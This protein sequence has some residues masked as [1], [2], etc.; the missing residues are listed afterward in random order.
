MNLNT[1]IGFHIMEAEEKY[2]AVVRELRKAKANNRVIT[3]TFVKSVFAN[4][5]FSEDLLETYQIAE[6]NKIIS[7]LCIT[8]T[9]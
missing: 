2:A 6:L 7:P 1:C 5:D 9:G 4:N 3:E 8:I